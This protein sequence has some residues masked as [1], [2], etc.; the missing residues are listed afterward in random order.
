MLTIETDEPPHTNAC[1]CCGGNTTSLTRFVYEDGAAFAIYYAAFADAH[2]ER[3]IQLAVGIGDWGEASTPR[4]RRAFALVLRGTDEQYEVTV[5]DAAESPWKDVGIIGR[6]LN[7]A[8]ALAD[9][10]I[11]DVFHI[12]D[13]M[14]EDD[15]EIRSY[16]NREPPLISDA[17]N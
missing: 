5:V 17:E 6:M 14:V 10:R 16:L 11:T 13:H 8:E 15:P 9:P 2:P 1:A 12:T 3:E 7:R 4:D